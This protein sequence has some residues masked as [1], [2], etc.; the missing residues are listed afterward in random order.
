MLANKLLTVVCLQKITNVFNICKV[1]FY[2][3]INTNFDA[4][5]KKI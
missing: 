5:I 1:Y 3:C 4:K 2:K